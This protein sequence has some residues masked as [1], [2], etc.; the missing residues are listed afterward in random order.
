VTASDPAPDAVAGLVEAVGLLRDQLEIVHRRNDELSEQARSRADEPLVRDLVLIADAAARTARD[1]TD[2]ETAEPADVAAALDAVADDLRRTLARVG[3]EAFEPEP[4][5]PFD[6]R[7]ATVLR[8]EP[9]AEGQP[10]GRVVAVVR[11]GYRSGE[12]VIRY[13]EVVVSRG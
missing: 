5:T 1:W 4:G 12:R 2:R 3:V 11:P 7:T 10:S 8:V 13:A 6:R 9:A